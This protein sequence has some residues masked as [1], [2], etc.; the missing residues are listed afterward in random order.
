MSRFDQQLQYLIA[1]FDLGAVD[2]NYTKDMLARGSRRVNNC[3]AH[4]P[5]WL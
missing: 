3:F 1:I 4:A 5:Q 2:T